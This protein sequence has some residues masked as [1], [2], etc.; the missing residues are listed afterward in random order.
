MNDSMRESGGDQAAPAAQYNPAQP[1][2]VGELRLNDQIR[3]MSAGLQNRELTLK[4][5]PVAERPDEKPNSVYVVS[6]SRT[7]ADRIVTEIH[8]NHR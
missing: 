8:I 3:Q 6:A 5:M 7:P 2:L 4:K 1:T